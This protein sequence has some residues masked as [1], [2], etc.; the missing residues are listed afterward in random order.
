MY[1]YNCMKKPLAGVI[2]DWQYLLTNALTLI[3]YYPRK[4]KQGDYLSGF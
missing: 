1:S 2:K 4:T 3:S